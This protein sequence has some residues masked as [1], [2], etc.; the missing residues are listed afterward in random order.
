MHLNLVWH[1]KIVFFSLPSHGALQ[2]GWI[3]LA[4]FLHKPSKTEELSIWGT[5]FFYREFWGLF[6]D[7]AC[8]FPIKALILY[9]SCRG[10]PGLADVKMRRSVDALEVTLGLLSFVGMSW[11]EFVPSLSKS[12]RDSDFQNFSQCWKQNPDCGQSVQISTFLDDF[13]FP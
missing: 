6:K 5:P 8:G 11:R 10:Y 2:D 12:R 3:N 9:L 13:S 1:W 4:C 7:R